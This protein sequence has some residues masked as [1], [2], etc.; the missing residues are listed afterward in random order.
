MPARGVSWRRT[1]CFAPLLALLFAAGCATRSISNSDSPNNY[2]GRD[3][4]YQGELSE[5]NVLGIDPS[6]PITEERITQEFASS[7]RIEIKPGSSLLL[8][9]SGAPFPDEPMQR[10]LAKHFQVGPFSGVLNE[11]SSKSNYAKALR[12]TAAQGG[13]DYIACYWGVL[14]TAQKTL[15]TKTVSWVPVVGRVLPDE[16]QQ[17]RI[18]L[19]L[20]IVD[21]RTGK[22]LMLTPEPIVDTTASARINR[23]TSDQ[24]QVAQLKEK[25]Y[26]ALAEQLWKIASSQ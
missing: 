24:S 15:A 4:L 2:Y 12:L 25:G 3:S 8:I 23:D 6:E 21:A 22:W 11:Q 17:M 9:Q 16:T 5:F 13:Y 1:L 18:R 14:E 19:K 26:T 10:E 20:A 7:H